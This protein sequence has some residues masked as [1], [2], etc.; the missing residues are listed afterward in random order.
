MLESL[1]NY[2]IGFNQFY[3][4]YE[5]T[6]LMYIPAFVLFV[7][8]FYYLI[9]FYIGKVSTFPFIL[10]YVFKNKLTQEGVKNVSHKRRK[11]N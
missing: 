7:F 2:Q 10:L 11:S 6:M 1:F 3:I 9:I 4:L 5:T 8:M